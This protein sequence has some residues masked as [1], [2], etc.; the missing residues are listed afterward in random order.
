[1]SACA[2]CLKRRAVQT[3]H[4]ITRNQARRSLTAAANRE[5]AD[6]KVPACRECNEAKYTLLRVPE[7]KAHLIT[8]LQSL[9]GGTYAVWDGDP[10]TLYGG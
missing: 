4:L 2:Y 5:N 10:S 7:S 8:V 3:D 9:T 6:Y 1:M